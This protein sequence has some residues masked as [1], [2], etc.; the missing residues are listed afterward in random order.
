MKHVPHTEREKE[1]N[2]VKIALNLVGINVD[3]PTTELITKSLE[4]LKEMDDEMN[5][6]DASK[7]QV[8]WEEKWKEYFD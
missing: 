1:V 2:N 8:A 7:I 5:I 6:E 3:Y 4:V